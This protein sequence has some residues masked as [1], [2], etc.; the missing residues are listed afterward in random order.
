[1][2]TA[3]R[4]VEAML[5]ELIGKRIGRQLVVGDTPRSG[6]DQQLDFRWDSGDCGIRAG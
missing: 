6:P 4:A 2:W 5:S 1:M 3:Q